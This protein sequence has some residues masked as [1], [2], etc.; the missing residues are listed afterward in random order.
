MGFDHERCDA[1][2]IFFA[3]SDFIFFAVFFVYKRV[4]KDLLCTGLKDLTVPTATGM[5]QLLLD[6]ISS[7]LPCCCCSPAEC[8][9]LE[10][11]ETALLQC[12]VFLMFKKNR[13]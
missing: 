7:F 6:K 5:C 9:C 12:I 4:D 2:F 1:D 8:L 3:A 13:I 11:P 10:I